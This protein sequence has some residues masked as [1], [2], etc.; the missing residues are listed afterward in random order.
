MMLADLDRTLAD[1]ADHASWRSVHD[2]TIGSYAAGKFAKPTSV[3]TYI[4]QIIAPREFTGN[5]ATRSGIR[6]EPM[7][8]AWAGATPNTLFVH[9]PEERGFGATVDGTIPGDPFAIVETK[10]K[11]NVI[12]DGPKP[13]ELR[14]MAWQLHCIPEAAECRFVWGEIVPD[15]REDGGWKLRRD[16]QTIVYPRDHPAIV[17]ATA[18]IVP[19]AHQVLAGVRAAR[20]AES[21]PF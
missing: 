21:T 7:L 13:A 2:V 5:A 15:D 4:R 18:L 9:H 8:L 16:P 17:A 19:I 3:E 6:W 1:T 12:V 14:Q 10:A 11:H 20:R